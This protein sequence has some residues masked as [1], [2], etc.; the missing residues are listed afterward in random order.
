VFQGNL[1][2]GRYGFEG[3]NLPFEQLQLRYEKDLLSVR[4]KTFVEEQP[5]W[6]AMQVNL[7]K[8]PYGVLKLFDHPKAEGLKILFSMQNS[9]VILESVQGHCYGLTCA[10]GK[11][12][13][14]KIPLATVLTGEVKLDGNVLSA[15]MPQ[16]VRQGMQNLKLGS[17][18]RWEGDLIL[19]EDGKK[20]FLLNGLL[21]AQEFEA[22][23]YR[24]R[25]LAGTIEATFKRVVLSN[26]KIDDLSGSIAIKKIELNKLQEWDLYIPHLVVHHLQPSLMRK[27]GEESL[28]AKP[29]TI[30]DFTLMDIR[31][32]LGDKSSLEGWGHLMFINQFKKESSILDAPLEV[33]KKFGLDPGL[34]TPVQGELQIELR[35][36][37]FYL[38]SLDNAFSEGD[39][40]EF[41]LLP[42]KDPSYID[43]DGKVH[44]DLKMRQD[45]LLKITEPFTLTIRG[46]LDKPRYGLQF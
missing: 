41:Y 2:P 34:L 16:E 19:W 24:F 22:L 45:V 46:S 42:Q 44:I 17:G 5:L 18:Y 37:K 20:G 14:R 3:K 36:D 32:K 12:T 27:V 38:V 40:A 6:G 43:L 4:A 23:G 31:G 21:M 8:E 29:F 26:M 25:S 7:F 30:K 13:K 11:S 1:K 33:I 28:S 9:K 15:L 39:R 10:L 35:G